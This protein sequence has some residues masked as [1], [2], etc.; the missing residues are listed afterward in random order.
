[1]KTLNKY[2][3]IA[4]R[5]PKSVIIIIL[6]VALLFDEYQNGIYKTGGGRRVCRI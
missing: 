2:A 3:Q 5:E 1:M 6:K 4:R